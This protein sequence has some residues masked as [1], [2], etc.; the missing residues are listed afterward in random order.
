MEL[1]HW[2]QLMEILIPRNKLT[3]W[4]KISGHFWQSAFLAPAGPFRMIM[5]HPTLLNQIPAMTWPVQIP[6]T[7][8]T[9]NVWRLKKGELRK[10]TQY[11]KSRDEL[12]AAV[13]DIW[14]T[15]IPIYI[16][17]LYHSLPLRIR[18]ILRSEGF[19]TKYWKYQVNL[20]LFE[21]VVEISIFHVTWV[22]KESVAILGKDFWALCVHI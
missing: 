12:I 10:R 21:Y 14:T 6:D 3:V 2:H 20:F 1:G 8:F 13:L 4:T 7:S 9:E 22:A 11:I 17:P 19:I 18:C 16:R 5:P 15:I